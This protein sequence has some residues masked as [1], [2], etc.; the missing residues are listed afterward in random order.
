MHTLPLVRASITLACACGDVALRQYDLSV[1]FWTNMSPFGTP[2]V[3][4]LLDKAK[5]PERR[6]AAIE[7]SAEVASWAL[8]FHVKFDSTCVVESRDS[9]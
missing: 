3:T 2:F 8:E 7:L 5:N 1:A 9:M 6:F 4:K